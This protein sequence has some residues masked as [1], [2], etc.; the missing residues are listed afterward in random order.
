MEGNAYLL[1]TYDTKLWVANSDTV[2]PPALHQQYIYGAKFK[3][4][5]RLLVDERQC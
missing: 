1:N 2:F 3:D 4:R 5:I